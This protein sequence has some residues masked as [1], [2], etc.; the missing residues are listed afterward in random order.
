VG[1]QKLEGASE[2]INAEYTGELEIDATKAK[3]SFELSSN[4]I[5]MFMA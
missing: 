1:R 3:V 5:E 2:C 4:W